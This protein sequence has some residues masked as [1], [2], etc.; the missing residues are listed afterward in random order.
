MI[1]TGT[2]IFPG[3]RSRAGEPIAVDDVAVDFPELTI[4]IAHGGRPRWME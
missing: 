2:S 1:H 3:A 4:V